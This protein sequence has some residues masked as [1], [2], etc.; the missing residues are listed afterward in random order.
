[1]VEGAVP[2]IP[3]YDEVERAQR[4]TVEDRQKMLGPDHPETLTSLNNLAQA[5]FFKG[6]YKEAAALY[7]QALA[8]REKY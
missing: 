4:Q 6:Q 1:V 2:L 7:R 8:G 5:L 3:R